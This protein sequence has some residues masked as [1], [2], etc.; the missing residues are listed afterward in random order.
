MRTTLGG[1][2]LDCDCDRLFDSDRVS[3]RGLMG[4]STPGIAPEVDHRLV[5]IAAL[6]GEYWFLEAGEFTVDGS[7]THGS[8]GGDADVP[9][10]RVAE[11]L[12]DSVGGCA[13]ICWVVRDGRIESVAPLRSGV[14]SIGE[15]EV[16]IRRPWR[17][18]L[19][20][21]AGD[22]L[23]IDSL[24]D[25]GECRG[26]EPLVLSAVGALSVVT[27]DRIAKPIALALRAGHAEC[28]G[29]LVAR[30]PDCSVL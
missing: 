13:A 19:R 24:E 18:F 28:V 27:T 7:L 5:G 4:G 20:W 14:D 21:L 2:W 12:I 9:R 3:L 23:L 8:C 17:G 26:R 10:I 15:A 30:H 11:L 1:L 22:A 29:R 16:L 25:W 6:L